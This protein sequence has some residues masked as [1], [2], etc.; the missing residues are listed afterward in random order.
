MKN[1]IDSRIKFV[2]YD[3]LGKEKAYYIVDKFRLDN[4]SIEEPLALDYSYQVFI[5]ETARIIKCTSGILKINNLKPEEDVGTIYKYKPIS[6]ETYAELEAP[7]VQNH[8]AVYLFVKANLWEGNLNIAKFTLFST[9]NQKLI[10]KYAKALTK[11]EMNNLDNDIEIAIF[12]SKVNQE[13]ATIEI[14][15]NHQISVLELIHL[16]EEHRH[17]IIINLKNLKDNYQYKG[18][19][20]LTASRNINGILVKPWLKTEYIDSGDYVDMGCFEMNRNTATINM[21]ITRKIK[22][23]K[24]EDKTP[25][26]EVAGLLAN[27]LTSYKNYTIVSDGKLNIKSL[28]IK[29]N[30]KKTFDI[31]KRKGVITAEKFDF[32]SC[33]TIDLENL[34][35]VSLVGKYKSLDSLFNQL[36]ELKILASIISAQL[37]QE[38]DTFVPEQ[39]NELKK[40]YLSQ[41]LYLNFP[42]TKAEGAIDTRISYK[43]D[44]G[45][46]DVLNLSKLYSANKF[47]ERR[48]EV[49]NTETGEI[50]SKPSLEMTLK[51]N[52][53]IRQK[54]LSPRMKITK[55]DELMKPIFDDFLGIERNGKI[56][57][58]LAQIGVSLNEEN[59]SITTNIKLQKPEKIATLTAVKYQLDKQIDNIYR[60]R[61]SPLVFYIG[62]TGLLPDGMEGKAMTGI[63]LAA[64]YPHLHFSKEEEEGLFFEIGK[65]LI[66]VY[67]KVEYCT[68]KSLVGIG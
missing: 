26:I 15:K 22:L 56:A 50:F 12:S 4:L 68:Q 18:V 61:I 33:H 38:S 35:L 59:A 30:S 23:I 65:S 17:S 24:T 58:I 1:T 46:Q 39:L 8:Q 5:S 14:P 13:L 10:A 55:V 66:G 47:L 32:R 52:I 7:V 20:R 19:K 51:P 25:I 6:K 27:N 53:A 9:S 29:I 21:L 44:I 67:E 40:H 2:I 54:S 41:N 28:Q 11:K 48:Y 45:S 31:L 63:Q 43:I 34:P 42:T 3:F 49:Y 16:L 62:A 37:K 60:D 64:K 57:V 36:A